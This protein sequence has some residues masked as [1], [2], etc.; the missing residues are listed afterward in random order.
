MG[1]GEGFVI[2]VYYP[3]TK[4]VVTRRDEAD[5]FTVK[6]VTDQKLGLEAIT[7]CG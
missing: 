5:P 2:Q 3:V 1:G 6:G 4:L 7:V